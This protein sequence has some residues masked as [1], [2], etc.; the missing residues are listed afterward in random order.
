[1][2]SPASLKEDVIRL[3]KRL[4]EAGDQQ[5]VI[6]VLES[7]SALP[8]TAGVLSATG[9]ARAVGKLRKSADA[10]T[11]AKASS[12]VA[13]WKHIVAKV[14][15]SSSSSTSSSGSSPPSLI[16]ARAFKAATAQPLL[17]AEAHTLDDAMASAVNSD[18]L[19][20]P[21]WPPL[22]AQVAIVSPARVREV[23]KAAPG[24]RLA[25]A[26]GTGPVIYWMSR[27]QRLQDNWALLVAQK[28]ALDAEVPLVVAFNLSPS[29]LGATARMYGFMLRALKVLAARARLTYNVEFVL[30]LGSPEATVVSLVKARRAS[31]LVCDYSPLRISKQWRS[32]VAAGVA[33]ISDAPPVLEVDAH[34]VSPVWATSDKCEFAA[35]C[36]PHSHTCRLLSHPP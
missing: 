35:R 24:K 33:K 16:V 1:M 11:A 10:A 6:D 14:P 21:S 32:N 4:A 25:K 20:M 18:S 29:F 27:D 7:I 5:S 12:I 28:M 17:L 31:G 23:G 3:E 36:A 8:M 22:D 34:N 13:K 15:P 2:Q 9:A 30:L 19:H 26:K